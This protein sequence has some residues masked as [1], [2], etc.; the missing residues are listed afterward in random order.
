MPAAALFSPGQTVTMSVD[1]T[2][3]RI[4]M[5]RQGGTVR[6]L[7]PSSRPVWIEFGDA[8]VTA[9]ISSS[10][11]MLPSSVVQWRLPMRAACLAAIATAGSGA[12]KGTPVALNITF[13]EGS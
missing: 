11:Q 9:N 10:V 3:S 4:H 1:V 2:S 5:P 8:A 12:D 6:I 7:N 13:G